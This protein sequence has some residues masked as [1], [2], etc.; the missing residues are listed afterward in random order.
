MASLKLKEFCHFR[1]GAVFMSRGWSFLCSKRHNILWMG[2]IIII[3]AYIRTGC[4]G[5]TGHHSVCHG[6]LGN[7]LL[8]RRPLQI[9]GIYIN[10]SDVWWRGKLGFWVM[11]RHAY[12]IW[13]GKEIEL[14][15]KSRCRDS[16]WCYEFCEFR[17]VHSV[18]VQYKSDNGLISFLLGD[19]YSVN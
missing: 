7:C 1:T 19:I 4:M 6:R 10:L 11:K 16:L 13:W 9:S 15:L 12:E 18:L 2:T 8:L 5:M 3:K 17:V 14:Q